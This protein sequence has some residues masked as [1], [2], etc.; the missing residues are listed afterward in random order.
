MLRVGSLCCCALLYGVFVAGPA[1]AYTAAGDRDFVATVLL[2]Q[3]GPA[4]ELYLTG[5]TQPVDGGRTSNASVTYDKLL[6][7]R[8]GIGV[9][10]AYGFQQTS[11]Q[12]TVTGWQNLTMIM[13]YTPIID[14]EDEL[15]VSV[16]FEREFGG[17]GAVHAG[18]DP[19]GAT[20]PLV[21]FG[22]GFGDI[23]ADYLK[24]FA[25]VGNAGAELGDTGARPNQWTGGLALE[26]SLPYL[27]SKVDGTA[28]PD[29]LRNLI[30]MI[31]FSASTP[32]SSP[33][34]TSLL[35]APGL[36]LA[37]Y[38]WE[39]GLEAQIPA[40]RAAGQGLGAAL[41]LHI[42]LDYLLP[43]SIGAPLITRR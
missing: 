29:S 9:T 25:I 40:S 27:T 41:Q 12:D 39:L 1:G 37:G 13:Q 11:G 24:P 23:A 34:Q 6:T 19:I 2:P 15:L 36:T 28:V 8:F 30:P 10:A 3:I 42:A 26:Y 18:A 33:G 5:V 16:G 38:G 14:A 7:D 20:T 32:I 22:K 35:V 4:D 17:T 21:Y 43:D 31:E